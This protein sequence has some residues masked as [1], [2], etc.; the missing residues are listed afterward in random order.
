MPL[1]VVGIKPKIL[2]MCP[3]GEWNSDLLVHSLVDSQQLSHA[4][5]VVYLVFRT[6]VFF[7]L[8][9]ILFVSFVNFLSVV[10][11]FLIFQTQCF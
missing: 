11:L 7:P 2:G 6:I 5:W 4:G 9:K 10:S 3:D 1:V 8:G